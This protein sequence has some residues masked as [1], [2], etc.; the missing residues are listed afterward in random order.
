LWRMYKN[1][2]G[3]KLDGGVVFQSTRGRRASTRHHETFKRWV[4]DRDHGLIELKV[5]TTTGVRQVST[6]PAT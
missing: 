6:Y 4:A 3:T 1:E 5:T 2:R